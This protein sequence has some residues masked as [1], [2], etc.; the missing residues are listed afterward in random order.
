ME[1]CDQYS[2]YRGKESLV[3]LVGHTYQRVGCCSIL[4]RRKFLLQFDEEEASPSS[5]FLAAAASTSVPQ[6]TTDLWPDVYRV[7]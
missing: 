5:T 3:N 7:A 4:V 2:L 1:R 6:P